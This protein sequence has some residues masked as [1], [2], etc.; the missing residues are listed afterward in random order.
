MAK[1]RIGDFL[2]SRG[3]SQNE[4]AEVLGISVASMSMKANGTTNFKLSEL[5]KL[6]ERYGMT[7]EEVID[8]FF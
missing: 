1:T 7:G 8:V 5:R 2:K 6:K 3:S 4:A